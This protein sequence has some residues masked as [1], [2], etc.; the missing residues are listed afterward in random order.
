VLTYPCSCELGADVSCRQRESTSW[1]RQTVALETGGLLNTLNQFSTIR[2]NAPSPLQPP[3]THRAFSKLTFRWN[4]Q[5]AAKLADENDVFGAALEEH[6]Q[7]GADDKDGGSERADV[8]RSMRGG[9]LLGERE[10]GRHGGW[11]EE[12]DIEEV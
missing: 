5:S 8:L 6:E 2:P 3:H 9:E 11:L 7:D 12:D 10:E 1:T 4:E